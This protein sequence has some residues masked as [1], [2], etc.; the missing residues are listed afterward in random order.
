MVKKQS[1]RTHPVS[2]ASGA[3]VARAVNAIMEAAGSGSIP[4]HEQVARVAYS[5]W[6]ARGCPEGSPEQD[7]FDA[8]AALRTMA[9]RAA[10]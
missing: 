4:D 6:Q 9:A 5:Y 10:A 3:S 7:W 8:E 1:I 2:A